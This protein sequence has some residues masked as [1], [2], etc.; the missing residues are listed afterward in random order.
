MT[1][2]PTR[3][4]LSCSE[5]QAEGSDPPPCRSPSRVSSST[6]AGA[7]AWS[8][9]RCPSIAD[10]RSTVRS[11]WSPVAASRPR[12]R[13]STRWTPAPS[14]L[15]ACL[16]SL[17]ATGAYRGKNGRS[18]LL[19]DSKSRV[20]KFGGSTKWNKSA[21][22]GAHWQHQ[23]CWSV[24]PHLCSCQLAQRQ[25]KRRRAQRPSAARLPAPSSVAGP[26]CSISI[27]RTVAPAM[28]RVAVMPGRCRR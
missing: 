3:L 14:T 12:A 11:P 22:L 4:S 5:G 13:R 20:S 6:A 23:P 15:R 8:G 25:R 18:N 28:S 2:V 17:C 26:R 24:L 10:T 1:S 21:E 9:T 7:S 27:P 16:H 19:P